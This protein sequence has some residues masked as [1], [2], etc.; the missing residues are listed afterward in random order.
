MGQLLV[1]FGPILVFMLIPLWIPV[2][3]VF[4]GAIT[5]RLGRARS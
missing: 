4:A 5:D 3:A 2:I 1:A